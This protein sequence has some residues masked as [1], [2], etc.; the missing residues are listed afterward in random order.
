MID[1]EF[2][3]SKIFVVKENENDKKIQSGDLIT[4]EEK[5][6]IFLLIVILIQIILGKKKPL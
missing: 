5:I 4:K 6:L 2:I 1:I 3:K